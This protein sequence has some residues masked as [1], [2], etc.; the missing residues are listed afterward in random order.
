MVTMP[1][2][3]ANPNVLHIIS[4]GVLQTAASVADKLDLCCASP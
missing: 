2:R 1:T 4:V 3:D